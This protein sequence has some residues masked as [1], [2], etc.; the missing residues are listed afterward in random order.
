MLLSYET[1]LVSEAG[2]SCLKTTPTPFDPNPLLTYCALRA[3]EM[4]LRHS[5]NEWAVA[6][7][8]VDDLITQVALS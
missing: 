7:C 2:R 3:C 6:C 8:D 1:C 4:L 5:W